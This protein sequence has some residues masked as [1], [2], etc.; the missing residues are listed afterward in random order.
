MVNAN[1]PGNAAGNGSGG[2]NSRC[3]KRASPL[4]LPP[5]GVVWH[6]FGHALLWDNVISPNFGFAH[7]AGDSLAAIFHDPGSK[8]PDRFDTFPWVQAAT[9]LG[10]RHDRAVSAGWGWFGANYNTQ[11]NGEQILS[12]TMSAS[13]G[14]SAVTPTTWQH[15]FALLNDGVSDFKAIGLLTAT[16]NDPRVFVTR[17]ETADK[18]TT[19]FEGIAGGALHKVIRWAFEKQGLFQPN[20]VPG[21]GKR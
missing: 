21:M 10:R 8:A 11:Y 17:L 19:T 16:T 18:T 6:Q 2:L 1:A 13:T 4:E 3:C 7:S 5:N 20:A 9:P 15:R 14:P 12:T